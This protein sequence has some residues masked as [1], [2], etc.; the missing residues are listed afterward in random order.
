MNLVTHF[1]ALHFS[2]FHLCSMFCDTG[3][4]CIFCRGRPV[5]E[6]LCHVGA[7]TFASFRASM[8]TY[9]LYLLVFLTLTSH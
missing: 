2:F 5:W 9:L 1:L 3:R 7:Y 6:R 8:K 4:P